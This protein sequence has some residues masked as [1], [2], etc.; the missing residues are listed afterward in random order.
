MEIKT[1]NPVHMH[2]M[3]VHVHCEY[4]FLVDR[5]NFSMKLNSGINNY[6]LQY[7]FAINLINFK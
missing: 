7:E 4:H 5:N 1:L 3:L 2:S 6:R